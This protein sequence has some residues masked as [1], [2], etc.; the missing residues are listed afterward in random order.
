[1][2]TTQLKKIINSNVEI[3][4]PQLG[5]MTM[6]FHLYN[7]DSGMAHVEVIKERQGIRFKLD[8]DV[9]SAK[10]LDS[11]NFKVSL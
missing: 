10:K 4:K 7:I 9:I 3:I 2:K 1:M 5:E 8:G 6:S 11:L